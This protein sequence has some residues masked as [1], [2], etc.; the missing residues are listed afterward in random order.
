Q[1]FTSGGALPMK[2]ALVACALL[3]L[4]CA[5]AQTPGASPAPGE[6]RDGGT[7]DVAF[8]S[9]YEGRQAPPTVTRNATVL[10]AAGP[11]IENGSVLM[12]NGEI[13]AVGRDI[14]VPSGA[15]VIDAR[16][17]WVTP[18][19]I[20]SHSHLGD[21]PAPGI[22]ADSDGNEMVRPNTAGV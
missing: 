17:K 21:Y 2:R 12:R 9:T 4:G 1:P 6:R 8:P 19:I 13:V 7:E 3:G 5:S 11:R 22:D 10:T 15:R 16:G 20:D 14:S 18:G